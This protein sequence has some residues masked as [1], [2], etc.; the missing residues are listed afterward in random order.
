MP[1]AREARPQ[2][3][4]SARRFSGL[5]LVVLLA[6]PSAAD[7]SRAPAAATIRRSLRC[8]VGRSPRSSGS[9]WSSGTRNARAPGGPRHTG[10]PADLQRATRPLNPV[11]DRPDPGHRPLRRH[12]PRAEVR[13]GDGRFASLLPPGEPRDRRGP[14]LPG[15]DGTARRSSTSRAHASATPAWPTS[16]DSPSWRNSGW[17][18]PAS[19]TSAWAASSPSSGSVCSTSPGR[20]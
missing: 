12:G 5:L 18:G 4:G 11:G 3:P 13:R 20:P 6:S 10:R 8:S 1:T 14:T 2:R 19:P 16:R 7:E 17:S 15:R 9:A